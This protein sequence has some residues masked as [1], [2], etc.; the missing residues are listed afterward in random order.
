MFAAPTRPHVISVL[1]LGM[2]WCF[3]DSSSSLLRPHNRI[4]LDCSYDR[5]VCRP[6]AAMQH[7]QVKRY[8]RG[9]KETDVRLCLRGSAAQVF[10]RVLSRLVKAGVVFLVFLVSMDSKPRPLSDT[11]QKMMITASLAQRFTIKSLR[12]QSRKIKC[13]RSVCGEHAL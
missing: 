8:P 1:L 5:V 7:A 13:M 9:A 10:K 4:C 2:R 11:C 3:D 6:A 12:F